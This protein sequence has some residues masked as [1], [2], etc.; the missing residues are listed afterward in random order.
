[1]D[2]LIS[3]PFYKSALNALV[4]QI[5]IIDSDGRIVFVNDSWKRFSDQNDGCGDVDWHQS[6]YI[7]CCESAAS[8]GDTDAIAVLD[9]LKKVISQ[10][11]KDFV[12]EYPCHC[13]EAKRWFLMRVSSFSVGGEQGFIVTHSDITQRKLAEEE[14][15]KLAYRDELTQIANR[16]HYDLKVEQQWKIAVEE[17]KPLGM[18]LIDI[19]DFKQINDKYGHQ[20]GD[21]VLRVLARELK[22]GKKRLRCLCSHRWR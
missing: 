12:H 4:E 7:H 18:L 21:E 2:K 20:V 8:N 6:N 15:F 17:N 22:V 16:R 3:E 19:D 9:G 11:I 13:P 5:A 14:I 1:M 10:S